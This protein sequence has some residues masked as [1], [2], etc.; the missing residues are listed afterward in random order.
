MLL[1]RTCPNLVQRPDGI[2]A[3]L[4]CALQVTIRTQ[5]IFFVVSRAVHQEFEQLV[6]GREPVSLHDGLVAARKT[7]LACP[8]SK[9]RCF[10][11][12]AAYLLLTVTNHD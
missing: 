8:V 4:L 9:V 12:K 2:S 3:Y 11:L 1:D 6:F 7:N 10:W 5:D